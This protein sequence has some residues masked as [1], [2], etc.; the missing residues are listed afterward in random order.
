MVVKPGTADLVDKLH[1]ASERVVRDHWKLAEL[2]IVP[3]PRLPEHLEIEDPPLPYFEF[4][5]ERGTMIRRAL[6]SIL[7][8]MSGGAGGRG[9]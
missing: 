9:R 1:E 8:R 7:P 3:V 4:V 6:K 5:R 2:S